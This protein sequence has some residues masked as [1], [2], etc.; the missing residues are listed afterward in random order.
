F[1]EEDFGRFA[2]LSAQRQVKVVGDDLTVTN[3]ARLKEA[4]AQRSIDAII[5]KPNQIGTLTETLETMRLA[6]E[7]GLDCIVSHRSGETTDDFIADLAYAFGVFGL[8]AGAPHGGER[9]VKYNR[10]LQLTKANP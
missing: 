8:K 6:R 9:V 7:N 2:Q 4:I 10:M 3:T 1:Y 5:I